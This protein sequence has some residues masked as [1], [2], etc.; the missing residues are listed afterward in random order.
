M[1]AT[2]RF[3]P[4]TIA[5]AAL[6]ALSI[7]GTLAVAAEESK[8]AEV[9]PAAPAPA[10]D[11]DML[12][13]KAFR[14]AAD[15][16]A[17]AV[18]RIETVG[19]MERVSKVLFGTG[20]TTGVAVD[21]EGYIV[22]SAFNFINK[23]ASILVR[24]PDGSRKPAT[25]VATDHN[26][27]LVLLKIA[28]D[29]PLPVP[30]AA[31]EKEMRVGQWTIA[32][33]RT[34]ESDRPNMNVGVMSALERI[35]GKAVQTDAAV[36]PNNYGGPLVDIRG[37]VLGVLVPL[38]PQSAE[39]VAGVEWYDSGIGFAV[40]L[41]QILKVLPKL[42]KG[43]DLYP[44]VIGINLGGNLQV[45]EATIGACQPN[46][47]A[48]DAGLKAN[49]KIVE[50]D[51]RPV[52]LAADVKREISRRYAGDKMRLV[53]LRG[54]ERIE[55]EVELVA[56]L[57]PYQQR[58][59]G[60]L[61]LRT[62]ARTGGVAVRY[63]YPKGPSDGKLQPA[64]VIVSVAG[65]AVANAAAL[66]EQLGVMK[67]GEE[68]EVE[69]RRGEKTEKAKVKLGVPAEDLPPAQ[70]PAARVAGK[71]FQGERPQVGAVSLKLPEFKNEAVL[72]VPEGYDPEVSHGVLLW[73]HAAG[74]FEQQEL[75]ARW[76]PLCDR[77]D[78]ILVAP[79]SADPTKWEPAEVE[80]LQKLLDKVK[81]TYN[82]DPA[83]MVAHGH[84]AGGTMAYSLAFRHRELLSAVAAV[85]AKS[86]GRP[87][88]NDPVHRLAVYA[89]T[90]KKSPHADAVAQAVAQFRQ[91][92]LPVTLKELGDAP[93]Y[94]KPE[95]LEELIR[96]IDMLDR[97]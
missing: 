29:K 24:M 73:L 17:P 40:P 68:V 96:W 89:A 46:S 6:A 67:A 95:E 93:R 43:E 14:A 86:S 94:L 58:M 37:R 28:A 20:P 63:V 79:K 76:K 59:L 77:F 27:M 80:Y 47:P 30:E 35:W 18:V 26:R 5:C 69:Y 66:R 57:E 83:R 55:R 82:T 22:S 23:P 25:L 39:E 49:D 48:A 21:P 62:G 3:H 42:K 52:Q 71:P 87:A 7:C 9:K 65:K 38:S 4:W 91:M 54:K 81:S 13:Q 19:G 88:A 1:T 56:K 51:G 90:A 2:P 50:I 84:E 72:Y 70:L 36:S 12:E 16:V 8:P 44:G 74:G 15:R 41:E 64:D 61:P 10:D 32:V 85:E 97:L 75:L 78:L 31:P 60:V 45:G 53:V 11:L 33:G 34:F 92:K